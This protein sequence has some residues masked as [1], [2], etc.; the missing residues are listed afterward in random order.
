VGIGRRRSEH[1]GHGAGLKP[2]EATASEASRTGHRPE[3]E[4]APDGAPLSQKRH[5]LDRQQTLALG[6]QAREDLLRHGPVFKVRNDA[7]S[8]CRCSC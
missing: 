8:G 3:A 6:H 7:E 4:R 5:F 1:L 2:S